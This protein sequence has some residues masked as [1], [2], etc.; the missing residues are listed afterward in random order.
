VTRRAV[1]VVRAV[2][3]VV[4]F[5]VYG[6]SGLDDILRDPAAASTCRGGPARETP[7]GLRSIVVLGIHIEPDVGILPLHSG[8]HGRKSLPVW[9]RPYSALKGMM[10]QCGQRTEHDP[11]QQG[12]ETNLAFHEHTSR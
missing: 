9:S 1:S 7:S 8:H 4:A 5:Y 11:K 12:R 10:A 6:H 2:L 3:G